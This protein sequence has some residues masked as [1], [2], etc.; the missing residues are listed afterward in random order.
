MLSELPGV[1]QQMGGASWCS[2]L[3]LYCSVA[4]AALST[5]SSPFVS[6]YP[7]SHPLTSSILNSCAYQFFHHSPIPDKCNSPPSLCQYWYYIITQMGATNNSWSPSST[8]FYSFWQ[9]CFHSQPSKSPRKFCQT[10]FSPR[11]FCQTPFSSALLH[12]HLTSTHSRLLCLLPHRKQKTLGS[13]VLNFLPQTTYK[14]MSILT[15]PLFIPY[16]LSQ[17]KRCHFSC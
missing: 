13:N 15:W 17:Q 11:K 8:I 9:S 4:V 14:L 10:P 7:F 2:L 16:L 5:P 1:T 6:T 3:A 12:L